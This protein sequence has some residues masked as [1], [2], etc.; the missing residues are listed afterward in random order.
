MY[1]FF[2]DLAIRDE[3][4]FISQTLSFDTLVALG[5]VHHLIGLA[6]ILDFRNFHR[7]LRMSSSRTTYH[8]EDPSTTLP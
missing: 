2:T 4:Y 3:L 1:I 5:V 7:V 6:T 8:V